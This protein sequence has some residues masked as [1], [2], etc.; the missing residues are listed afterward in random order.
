MTIAA[1][2]VAPDGTADPSTETPPF[3]TGQIG[4]PVHVKAASGATA[5]ATLNSATWLTPGG[6]DVIELT[7][8]GTSPTPFSYNDTYVVAGYGG[9]NQPFT[10]PNDD[11]WVG[12]SPG[13]YSKNGK[14]PL[15][16]GHVTAGQTAHG[17][18]FYSLQSEG[19]FYIKLCD[20]DTGGTTTE[21]GWKLHT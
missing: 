2:S 15:G 20:P 5:D 8:R 10:H 13:N 7:I 6:G 21:A 12:A 17:I 14:P 19:D 11:H 18:V 9:G 3:P 4:E 1:C 16:S